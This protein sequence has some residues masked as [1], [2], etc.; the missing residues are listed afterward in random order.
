MEPYLA[1]ASIFYTA[2]QGP[3]KEFSGLW[4]SGVCITCS[5]SSVT[6]KKEGIH[7]VTSAVITYSRLVRHIDP[8]PVEPDWRPPI[9]EAGLERE[10]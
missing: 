7:Y 4:G 3:G 8:L 10:D 1:L 6:S 9:R 5:N 2:S